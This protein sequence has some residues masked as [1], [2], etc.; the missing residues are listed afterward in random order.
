MNTCTRFFRILG[1]ALGSALYELGGFLLPFL[2]VGIW[3]FMGAFGVLFTIPKVDMN[4]DTD[5]TKGKK[6]TILDL[7]KV[8]LGHSCH[9]QLKFV[10]K[11]IMNA[12]AICLTNY[13]FT[14]E[15]EN[16]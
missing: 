1:P 16:C 14:N 6:L 13:F 15:N 4:H 10:L 8:S 5:G 12:H 7:V 9:F 11:N 2:C 3:C